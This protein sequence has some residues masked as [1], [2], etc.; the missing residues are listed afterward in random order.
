MSSGVGSAFLWHRVVETFPTDNVVAVFADVN[1]EHADNYRFLRDLKALGL[2]ELVVL[3]N[4]GRT[5]WDVFRQSKFLGN[6]RVDICSRELKRKPIEEWIATTYADPT[7][8]V[9]H[10]G[11]DW[12]EEHRIPAIRDGWARKGIATA[13]DLA[14]SNGDKWQALEWLKSVGIAPPPAHT[15]QVSAR[16]LW[17][18]LRPGGHGSVR[19]FVRAAPRR[20]R[21]M[22]SRGRSHAPI[23]GSR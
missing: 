1:G 5:I 23:F 8:V 21:E 7:N 2:S 17:W 4:G 11:I 14:D 6:D 10:V 16:Q 15:T 18:R 13:Y 9:M 3:D 22:G 19:S 20:I 12:T